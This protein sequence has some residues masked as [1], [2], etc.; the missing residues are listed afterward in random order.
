MK[1]RSQGFLMIYH[2]RCMRDVSQK[3]KKCSSG[4]LTI[5]PPEYNLS[6]LNIFIFYKLYSEG[7]VEIILFKGIF[8]VENAMISLK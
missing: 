3:L 7:S 6:S 2:E 5:K 8:V 1:E 4:G